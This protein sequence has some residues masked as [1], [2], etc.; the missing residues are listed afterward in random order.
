MSQ[1]IFSPHYFTLDLRHL[2]VAALLHHEPLSVIMEEKLSMLVWSCRGNARYSVEAWLTYT[3]TRVRERRSQ[4]FRKYFFTDL[5][6]FSND[7]TTKVGKNPGREK[8]YCR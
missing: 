8:C 1:T 3:R 5:A 4:E 2:R 6:E 7:N